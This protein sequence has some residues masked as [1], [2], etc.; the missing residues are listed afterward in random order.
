MKIIAMYLPQYHSIPENDQFW[1]KG[2]TDWVTVRKAE[3]LYE[4]HQQPKIPLDNRYYDLSK[5]DNVMWQAKLAH[6]HGIYGFGVYHYWFNNE[7]NLLT[8]P[9]EMMRDTEDFP[10][11]YY[12]AWDNCLWKRSWSNVAGNDWAP[13]ADKKIDKDTG[14]EILIPYILGE[15]PDWRKHYDYVRTHFLSPNYI[16]K[17]NKPLFTILWYSPVMK[18][19]CECW[20]KWAKEDGFDGM[21]FIYKYNAYKGIPEDAYRYNYQPQFSGWENISFVHRVYNKILRTMKI[22]PRKKMRVMDYDK[23]WGD[24]LKYA[25]KH[26]ES[27]LYHGAFVGYDD[28]P[29]RGRSRSI[30]LEGSTPEKFGKYMK[31]LVDISEKQG[32]E[33]I[34]LTAWNEWGEGAYM[35]PD[36]VN[37]YAYL[38]A[39][40]NCRQ[41][42]E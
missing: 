28:S 19:M 27:N 42:R 23:V 39:L 31:R 36:T 10:V 4:G 18:D 14:V 32:K 38:E 21:C 12:L 40:K 5:K 8:R 37:G 16:K 35:E 11:K 25:E 6:E 33:Y 9:T 26:P 15:E 7:K 34:F 2:F 22:D 30:I 1:G 13:M 3:P 20:D 41:K 29:R 24:I 17:D